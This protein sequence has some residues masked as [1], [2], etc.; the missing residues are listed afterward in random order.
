CLKRSDVIQR[1]LEC[2]RVERGK[3]QC[4]E[5]LTAPFYVLQGRDKCLVDGGLVADDIRRILQAPMGLQR[6]AEIDR[7]RFARCFVADRDDDVRWAMLEG[8]IAFA[9]E[10]CGRNTGLLQ[11]AQAAGQHLSLGKA[12]GAHGFEAGRCQV[13]EQCLGQDAAAAIGRAH[14]QNSHVKLQPP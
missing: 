12:P 8:V 10:P 7:A 3:R 2:Q 14:E 9:A 13:V 6:R 1:A 11:G 4:E 5:R